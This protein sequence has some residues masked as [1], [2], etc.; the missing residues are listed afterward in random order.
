MTK[1][2]F[3]ELKSLIFYGIWVLRTVQEPISLGDIEDGFKA[4][5]EEEDI[6]AGLK[7]KI[8][9]SKAKKKGKD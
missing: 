1:E 6:M 4:S 2:Q 5:Q 3:E 8:L 9:E 7:K